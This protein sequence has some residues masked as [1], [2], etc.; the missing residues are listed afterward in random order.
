MNEK[1]AIYDV[2]GKKKFDLDILVD[3]TATGSPGFV[4][5]YHSYST[6]L[7]TVEKRGLG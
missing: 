6:L 7:L 4:P 5:F 2:D 3:I 1:R